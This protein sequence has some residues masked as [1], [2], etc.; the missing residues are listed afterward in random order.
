MYLFQ[1]CD[2]RDAKYES[3]LTVRMYRESRVGARRGYLTHDELRMN[4]ETETALRSGRQLCGMTDLWADSSAAFR[5]WTLV[6]GV[7]DYCRSTA[8]SRKKISAGIESGGVHAAAGIESE[9]HVTECLG[10]AVEANSL[11]LF[12]ML[13][14]RCGLQCGLRRGQSRQGWWRK[15]SGG[16]GGGG[17][18]WRGE[19][20]VAA[21]M[22]ACEGRG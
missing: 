19:G 7:I 12:Q 20:D 4:C 13:P 16:E 10:L 14:A 21:R 2:P 6:V 8:S 18:W 17:W 9:P 3:V 15:G 11:A 1:H 5:R 22:T